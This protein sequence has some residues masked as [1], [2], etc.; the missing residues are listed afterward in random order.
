MKINEDRI[1]EDVVRAYD[2]FQN[3]SYSKQKTFGRD[4]GAINYIF[5]KVCNKYFDFSETYNPYHD[6]LFTRADSKNLYDYASFVFLYM[7]YYMRLAKNYSDLLEKNN[8]TRTEPICGKV[9]SPA[10]IQEIML[11]FFNEQ[12]VDKYKIVKSMF[13]EERIEISKMD[14]DGAGAVCSVMASDIKPYIIV[15]AK[16]DRVRLYDLRDLAHELGHAVEGHFRQNRYNKC[17]DGRQLILS[18]LV[19][20]FYEHEFCRYLQDKRIETKD[21]NSLINE[22]HVIN[23]FFSDSLLQ[24]NPEELTMEG[25]KY[26]PIEDSQRIN[27]DKNIEI[28]F[29][30]EG[31]DKHFYVFEFNFYKPLKYALGGISALNLS[32]IKKQDPKEFNRLWDYFLSMRT[33]MSE[34]DML[35]LFNMSP[36]ELINCSY[37]KEL[38]EGDVNKYNK[39][40]KRQL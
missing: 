36:A 7:E 35:D 1:Y 32:E 3:G 34:E 28:A 15:D 20:K 14:L 19:S 21:A 10:Q 39:Q 6:K 30:K 38:I 25:E 2:I 24:A 23:K 8:L 40:L 26:T 5:S 29:K 18:E 22:F 16:E 12:G 9:F 11:D 17:H 4:I 33:L 27:D 37:I 13:D 31:D